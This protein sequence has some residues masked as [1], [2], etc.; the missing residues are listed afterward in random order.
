[1]NSLVETLEVDENGNMNNDNNSNHF[2]AHIS[3]MLNSWAHSFIYIHDLFS[4]Q[5]RDVLGGRGTEDWWGA[6][7]LWSQNQG[8]NSA[9]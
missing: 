2:I 8:L 1:M 3:Y 7:C 4:F 6:R 9:P 5:P